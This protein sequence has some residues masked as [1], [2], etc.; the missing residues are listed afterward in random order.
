MLLQFWMLQ[1]RAYHFY[2]G[3]TSFEHHTHI[4]SNLFNFVFKVCSNN[5]T[6]CMFNLF[7]KLYHSN[8]LIFSFSFY[9]IIF[10]KKFHEFHQ[11][12]DLSLKFLRGVRFIF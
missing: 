12:L 10:N 8:V 11:R 9:L 1:P 6:F 7:N 3:H 5:L 4:V 2:I